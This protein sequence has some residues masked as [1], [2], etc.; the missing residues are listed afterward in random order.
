M[1]DRF[2]YNPPDSKAKSELMSIDINFFHDSLILI[3]CTDC[4]DCTDPHQ[5]S[6]DSLVC[7]ALHRRRFANGTLDC[8]CIIN[9]ICS[10][11]GPSGLLSC[12]R[13]NYTTLN[14]PGELVPMITSQ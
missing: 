9:C 11:S 7:I 13:F 5:G 2:V 8:L 14:D 12:L 4:I 3:R 1:A 10:E 6:K